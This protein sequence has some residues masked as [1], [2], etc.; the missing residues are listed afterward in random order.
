[1]KKLQKATLRIFLSCM[2]ITAVLMLVAIWAPVEQVTRGPNAIM[3]YTMT[4]FVIG[5]ASFLA[6]FT[7]VV[8][9]I[10]DNAK[11]N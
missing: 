8:L 1:M 5:L 10:R 2:T 9:E 11:S 6:W 7:S 3:Q 4:F